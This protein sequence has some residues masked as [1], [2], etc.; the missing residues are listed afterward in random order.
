M[1]QAMYETTITVTALLCLAA[2]YIFS[3]VVKQGINKRKLAECKET[4]RKLE[5]S[6]DEASRVLEA[7]NN[8]ISVLNRKLKESRLITTIEDLNKAQDEQRTIL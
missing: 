4:I 3:L 1:E 8:Q 7:Q 6:L 5:F 2:V